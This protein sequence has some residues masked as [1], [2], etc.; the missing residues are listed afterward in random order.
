MIEVVGLGS[1]LEC[2]H[3]A[4]DTDNLIL[5]QVEIQVCDA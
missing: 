4:V 1:M 3:A 2:I 5:L